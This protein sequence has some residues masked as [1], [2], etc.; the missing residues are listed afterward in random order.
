M[1]LRGLS[2][3]CTCLG[4]SSRNTFFKAIISGCPFSGCVRETGLSWNIWLPGMSGIIRKCCLGPSRTICQAY[5]SLSHLPEWDTTR[6]EALICRQGACPMWMRMASRVTHGGE[7]KVSKLGKRRMSP[8]D[9]AASGKLLES[10]RQR[11]YAP[12]KRLL[13]GER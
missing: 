3:D 1:S 4:S 2:M 11:Q 9:A 7:E 8:R 6:V 13:L 5:Q 10:R 12:A